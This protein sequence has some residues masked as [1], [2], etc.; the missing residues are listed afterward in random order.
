MDKGQ[1]I[2]GG[3]TIGKTIIFAYNHEHAVLIVEKF[4][5]LYPELGDDF[6]QLIDNYVN[7]AQNIIDTFEVRENAADS[8]LSGHA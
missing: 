3:D 5:K 2:N 6:C 4:K 1:K 8:G 7:Y